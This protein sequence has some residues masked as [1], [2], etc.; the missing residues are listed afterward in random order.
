MTKDSVTEFHE[1]L[2]SSVD[3][4]IDAAP[5]IAD[6][7]AHG[8]EL[9]AARRRRSLGL[10]VPEELVADERRGAARALAAVLLLERVVDVLGVSPILV[11]GP[12]IAARYPAP[13]L[14]RFGDIDLLV[15]DPSTAQRSLLAAGFREIGDPQL[16]RDIH[17]LRPLV[18]PGVPL[19]LE[20]HSEPKW[21]RPWR[22]PPYAD[23]AERSGPAAC[24][25]DGVLAP[26][27]AD[28]AVLVAVHSWAHEP[29]RRVS[30]LID[31]AVLTGGDH[32]GPETSAERMGVSRVWATTASAVEATLF[33]GRKTFASRTWARDL[34]TARGRTVLESHLARLFSPFGAQPPFAACLTA[35]AAAGDIVLPAPD[36]AWPRKLRRARAALRHAGDSRS[37]HDRALGRRGLL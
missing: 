17:H 2:W 27:R 16:F 32:R 26:S 24:G 37:E 1:R 10:P 12:E 36:E 14:R 25:V 4:V 11:K 18:W 28:H 15:E 21:I 33:A 8:L 5:S 29:L 6:L 31:V 13:T 9:L 20:L 30:D 35:L 19:A 3:V 23:I 7:R 34:A 22:A